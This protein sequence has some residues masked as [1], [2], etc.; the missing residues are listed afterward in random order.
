MMTLQEILTYVE[1]IEFKNSMFGYDKDEVDIQLDKICDDVEALV[2]QKDKEIEDLKK[3]LAVLKENPDAQPED[4]VAAFTATEDV[5]S[6][7]E[8]NLVVEE[9]AQLKGALE[10][11]QT[12]LASAKEEAAQANEAVKVMIA[13]LEEAKK[14]LEAA[15]AAQEAQPEEVV[16]AA[17]VEEPVV[18]EVVEEIVEETVEE[19]AEEKAAPVPQTTDEAY[20]QYMMYADLLCKQLAEAETAH[21]KA[22]EGAQVEVDKLLADAKTQA[23]QILA[24]AQNVMDVK[25]AEAN[26]EAQSVITK[27]NEEAQS[28]I[29][30]AKAEAEEIAKEGMIK[31]TAI[32]EQCRELASKKE[33]LISSLNGFG[34]EIAAVLAK[35][36]E[37]AQPEE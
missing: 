27:A 1:E 24:D 32:E 16:G 2:S 20:K 35:V 6:R 21:A 18:E 14:Q 3:T 33:S 7:S 15:K 4:I 9:C 28:T 8:Y 30:K 11:A 10:T 26:E 22:V 34:E 36:N 5:V 29:E 12:D 23:D 17:E 37:V 31:A 19:P 25:S 13:D